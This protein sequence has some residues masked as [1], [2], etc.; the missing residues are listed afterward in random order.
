MVG[1]G[2]QCYNFEF[3]LRGGRNLVWGWELA[4]APSR[5]VL[6]QFPHQGLEPRLAG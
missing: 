2:V 6:G 3:E 5:R 4:A 1:R